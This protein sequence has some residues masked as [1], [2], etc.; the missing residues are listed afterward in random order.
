MKKERYIT[1]KLSKLSKY[2]NF[3]NEYYDCDI[4]HNLLTAIGR[5]RAKHMG[6]GLYVHMLNKDIAIDDIK[7]SIADFM[8]IDG[9]VCFSEIGDEQFSN[10]KTKIGL[11]VEGRPTFQSDCDCW[12]ITGKNGKRKATRVE[13]WTERNETWL[14]PAETKAF[15]IVFEGCDKLRRKIE[16]T[17]F[18]LGLCVLEYKHINKG[19]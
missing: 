2:D 6:N 4:S 1:K 8:A 15:G 17:A 3:D 12:S 14:V 18:A 13:S 19:E 10:R 11:I 16:N 5:Q 7:S 9:E